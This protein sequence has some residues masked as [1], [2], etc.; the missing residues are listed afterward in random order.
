MSSV[1][2]AD[3]NAKLP[4]QRTEEA[5]RKRKDLFAQ[6]DPNSNGYVSLAEVDR[7][8]RDVLHSDELFHCKPAVIR[9]FNFAKAKSTGKDKH[10]PDFLEFREFR[11]F[12][13]TLR[14]YFEYYQAFD[15][16][17]TGD[18]NRIS[19]EEFCSKSV[20]AAI[21]KWVGPVGDLAAEFDKI[22]A[23][24]GGQILFNE[25]V[26]WALEKNLDLEDDVE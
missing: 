3:V 19:K 5:L 21:E 20:K 14:Q 17:D 15:R 12:L 7:G 13:Q 1:N 25:F 6:F 8:L 16:I 22:D 2:W 23:N 26:D 18:D 11:L 10:G 4:Y 24:G 9:A